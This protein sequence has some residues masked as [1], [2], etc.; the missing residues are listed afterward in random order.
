MTLLFIRTK[1]SVHQIIFCLSAIRVEVS[2]E[3]WWLKT[4]LKCN[5]WFHAPLLDSGG[6][7]L[8]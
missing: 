6:Q 8:Y 2:E 1:G 5:K 3:T 4:I 7:F